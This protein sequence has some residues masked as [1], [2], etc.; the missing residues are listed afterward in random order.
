M[1]QGQLPAANTTLLTSVPIRQRRI[2]TREVRRRA[3]APHL[4]S[5]RRWRCLLIT[6]RIY[7][8]MGITDFFS[9]FH[10]WTTPAA[11]AYSRH[12]I[13]RLYLFGRALRLTELTSF[14]TAVAQG[15]LYKDTPAPR[16]DYFRS[17]SPLQYDICLK[18]ALDDFFDEPERECRHMTLHA[19]Y[20]SR[21]VSSIGTPHGRY[22]SR[23]PAGRPFRR[24]YRWHGVMPASMSRH[25]DICSGREKARRITRLDS[26][27]FP[28][29]HARII[30]RYSADDDHAAI[31]RQYY[32]SVASRQARTTT[33]RDTHD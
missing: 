9:R 11:A 23:R 2:I 13:A 6:H 3:A 16:Y 26:Y 7:L 14:Q 12:A 20:A 18:R 4:F 33:K 17:L 15:R 22:S 25:M 19:I 30:L 29:C 31:F 10:R 28:F 5:Y 21:Q 24:L 27:W 1:A 32:A 8:V